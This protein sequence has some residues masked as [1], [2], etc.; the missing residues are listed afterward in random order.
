VI[1]AKRTAKVFTLTELLALAAVMGILAAIALPAYSVHTAKG[2]TSS[3][4][5]TSSERNA[6]TV[7]YTKGD[8]MALRAAYP[9]VHTPTQCAAVSVDEAGAIT[10]R[11]G[12][13]M[14]AAQT[15][16]K[17]AVGASLRLHGRHVQCLYEVLF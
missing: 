1:K 5:A 12:A 10:V 14:D 15:P 2:K 6:V 4:H 3:T 8:V 17:T 9:L 11:L 7:Y 16:D 13:G